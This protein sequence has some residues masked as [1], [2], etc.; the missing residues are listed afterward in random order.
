MLL[1]RL[2]ITVLLTFL[3]LTLAVSAQESA[4]T[5]GDC[6]VAVAPTLATGEVLCGTTTV[7]LQHDNPN[8]DTIELA[9]IVIKSAEA[10][11]NTPPL[12]MLQGGPGGSTLK[13]F[14]QYLSLPA[15][16]EFTQ[17]RDVI[18]FD[19]RGTGESTPS[20]YCDEIT[21]LTYDT[22]A[23]DLRA[24]DTNPLFVAAVLACAD[25]LTSAGINLSAFDSYENAKDVTSVV[26]ALGYKEYDLYG[27]SYG[28]LLAQHV[29]QISPEGLRSVVLDAVVPTDRN[30]APEVAY[31]ANRAFNALFEACA[32]DSACNELYPNLAEKLADGVA[33]LNDSPVTFQVIDPISIQ[34]RDVVVNGDGYVSL[35]F[36]ALYSAEIVPVLPS[37]IDATANGNT[38]WMVA[39][40]PLISLSSLQDMA[41][42]MN[43]AVIC[44]EDADYTEADI[45]I[46]GIPAYI[47][48]P[49]SAQSQSYLQ[50]C[51]TLA[52]EA[53]PTSV[54][55]PITVDIPTLLVSGGFDPI[56][57][58][59]YAEQVASNLPNDYSIVV[60]SNGH[61]TLTNVCGASI[62]N[63]FLQAPDTAPNTT[64]LADQQPTFATT[65]TEIVFEARE[66][67]D[68]GITVGVPQGWQDF[69][70]GIYSGDQT[71][72]VFAAAPG[73]GAQDFLSFIINNLGASD[74]EQ[75][76]RTETIG[77][78]EWTLTDLPLLGIRIAAR[79]TETGSI[80]MLLQT[81]RLTDFVAFADLVV[82]PALSLVK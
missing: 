14:T 62:V 16:K 56:T 4:F 69:G 1:K 60:N 11:A 58:A 41:Y 24:E 6:A 68:Y 37:F 40:F 59:E 78:A 8:G 72:I 79:D 48:V 36:S 18:L 30:F 57:P 20:L 81:Q 44:A 67:P 38:D 34:T 13:V 76:T 51:P 63:A 46:E 28:S 2:I 27:V 25:R 52:I 50:V 21:Q 12:V 9:T 77:E 74:F 3:G 66:L 49:F 54:D 45:N 73:F 23:Q 19:Q 70:T 75:V 33:R 26:Q 80:I 55:D 47:S 5:E 7:P 53:L 64:C 32:K 71:T 35:L 42:G 39:I 61:G 65:A 10:D 22:L 82:L 29:M 43:M 31:T 17:G 15:G